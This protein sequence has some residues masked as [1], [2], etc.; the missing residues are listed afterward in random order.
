MRER[1]V[2]RFF[3]RT[4]ERAGG[5]T[6]KFVS[7]SRRGVADRIACL[8][9]GATWFVELKAKRGRVAGLQEIFAGQMAALNQRHVFLATEEQVTAWASAHIK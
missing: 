5:A 3:V 2:E 8:P 9:D 7:P 4:V 6:Y 1:N